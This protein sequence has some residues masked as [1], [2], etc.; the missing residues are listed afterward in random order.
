MP[1]PSPT[2]R[3]KTPP[4]PQMPPLVLP[5]AVHAGTSL[6]ASATPPH[7]AP[8]PAPPEGQNSQSYATHQG[9]GA[10]QA[11]LHAQMQEINAQMQALQAA[12]AKMQADM[13]AQHQAHRIEILEM[14]V[15]QREGTISDQRS[16]IENQRD[17]IAQLNAQGSRPLMHQSSTAMALSYAARG[18]KAAVEQGRASAPSSQ[19]GTADRPGRFRDQVRQGWN[20][21]TAPPTHVGAIAGAPGGGP[22]AIEAAPADDTGQATPAEHADVEALPVATPRVGTASGSGAAAHLSDAYLAG[23]RALQASAAVTGQVAKT[24]AHT[25]REQVAIQRQRMAAPVATAALGS[26][27]PEA[28]RIPFPT[29]LALDPLWGGAEREELQRGTPKQAAQWLKSQARKFDQLIQTTMQTH[30]EA[31]SENG[32]KVVRL[33]QHAA[34]LSS[35]SKDAGSVSRKF[36]GNVSP[37]KAEKYVAAIKAAVAEFC[38]SAPHGALVDL[39]HPSKEPN[40][41]LD[42]LSH[43]N[44]LAQ[45]LGAH[46][47]PISYDSCRNYAN[48]IKNHAK[49]VPTRQSHPAPAA[50]GS[51]SGSART[52]SVAPTPTPSASGSRSSPPAHATR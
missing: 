14:Q 16:T 9:G 5:Q 7:P 23:K 43:W 17:T 34:Y 47:H 24:A 1:S 12:N 40:F 48:Y 6:A 21:I 22:L 3:P 19:A 15:T 18:I 31:F 27:Q 20:N 10:M 2:T 42:F 11:S 28:P 4:S 51:A 39:P 37:R 41:E 30:P 13:Q 45:F 33:G 44:P 8:P 36:S 46:G 26:G 38:D 49:E 32:A 50:S 25:A 52:P 35:L 29:P